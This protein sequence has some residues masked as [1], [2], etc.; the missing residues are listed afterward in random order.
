MSNTKTTDVYGKHCEAHYQQFE[1]LHEL[2]QQI[3]CNI[4]KYRE[5]KSISQEQLQAATGLTVAGY[6]SGMNDMTLTTLCI[7]SKH[8]DVD[9]YQLLK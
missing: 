9:I 7:L 3:A 8:L 1:T 4:K 2:L 5:L 6:E